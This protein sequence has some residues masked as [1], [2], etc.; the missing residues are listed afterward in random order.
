MH[1]KRLLTGV[2]CTV[3]GVD[4]MLMFLQILQMVWP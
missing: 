2:G 3:R 4:Q 1:Y